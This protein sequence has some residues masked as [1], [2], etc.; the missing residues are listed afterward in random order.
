ML[1][2]TGYLFQRE[3]STRWYIRLQSNVNGERRVVEKSLGT[4]NRQ[5]AE[6]LSLPLIAEHK[7]KLLA[8][9]PHFEAV[10]V[11]EFE[12]GRE[13]VARDGHRVIAT[14]RELIHIK[15]DGTTRIEPNGGPRQ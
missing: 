15:P 4:A 9:R 10:W 2:R 12:P 3:G 5:E 14:D 13:H 6:I 7:A 8:A 1:S 11:H